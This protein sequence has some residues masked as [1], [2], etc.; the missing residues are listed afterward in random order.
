MANLCILKRVS[1][2]MLLTLTASL[3]FAAGG[4]GNGGSGT[5]G[6]GGVYKDGDYLTFAAAGVKIPAGDVLEISEIPGLSTA[7][8]L[9]SQL[10]LSQ[11][12]QSKLMLAIFPVG[13]RK[14]HQ[15]TKLDSRLEEKIKKGYYNATGGSI[16]YKN[17]VV[18]AVT[19]G[20]DTYLLPSF[21]KIQAPVDSKKP[22]D[23]GQ[24]A[25]L[26]QEALETVVNKTL[27]NGVPSFTE[28]YFTHAQITVGHFMLEHQD[29]SDFDEDLYKTLEEVGSDPTLRFLAAK[30][31][32]IKNNRI[33]PL[34]DEKGNLLFDKLGHRIYTDIGRENGAKY[35]KIKCNLIDDSFLL[36]LIKNVQ[37]YPSSILLK[38]IMKR[39][40]VFDRFI[41]GS[42]TSYMSK[43][44]SNGIVATSD[45]R[46]VSIDS[47]FLPRDDD[48]LCGKYRV[49][50]F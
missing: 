33:A 17:L 14:Y 42:L 16:D 13:D 19:S 5:G 2:T 27:Q 7:Q 43:F 36:A 12:V 29:W 28:E 34:L 50:M 47:D 32:D 37:A 18:Y 21:F 45:Y 15:I 30:N 35:T 48:D 23:L 24:A 39:P 38:Q 10:V 20:Q 25:V 11:S 44:G 1:L 9:V 26:Y 6:G 41:I 46:T 22:N 49:K 31:D 4:E 40:D 3:G 8:N